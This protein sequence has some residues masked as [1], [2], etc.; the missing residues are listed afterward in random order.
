MRSEDCKSEETK[1]Q[2]EKPRKS[3]ITQLF[4]KRSS[5]HK[6]LRLELEEALADLSRQDE[7]FSKQERLMLHNILQL[8][9]KR[10]ANIMIPRA[11]IV[12]VD[13]NSSLLETL[14]VFKQS[15]HSRLPVYD[16]T[17]DEPRGMLHIRDVL[18]HLINTAISGN[19]PTP[20]LP[21]ELQYSLDSLNIIRPV[22]FVPNSMPVVKLM[23][24][25]QTSRTQ[26]ALVIDEHGGTDGLVCLEDIVELI[27]GEI[28]DEHDDDEA[29]IQKEA[30]NRYLIDARIELND[31]KEY[32]GETF[33]IE[34]YLDDVDTL[35]GLLISL[36]GHI[37]QAG[38]VVSVAPIYQFEILIAD[39]RRVQ[40]VRLTTI[41][42]QSE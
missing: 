20:I 19:I 33:D 29:Y 23:T 3:L 27:V 2:Q 15:G 17:L 25:M 22:L 37:P 5:R 41:H 35:S 34:Q 11:E 30:D 28:E 36:S 31:L 26:M 32:L 8:D 39:S 4:S 12:A 21:T 18:N 38:E 24:R 10:V 42:K 9:D 1:A 16:E 40:K 14:E 13:S 6:P 7:S